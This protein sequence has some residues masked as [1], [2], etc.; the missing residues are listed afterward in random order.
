MKAMEQIFS[1]S[2]DTYKEAFPIVAG[3]MVQEVAENALEAANHT[4]RSAY[5]A[6][7]G[8][9]A[10]EKSIKNAQLLAFTLSRVVDHTLWMNRYANSLAAI[11]NSLGEFKVQTPKASSS[12]FLKDGRE[13]KVPVSHDG[14]VTV[15]LQRLTGQP[16]EIVMRINAVIQELD[17]CCRELD[18]ALKESD[19][20]YK[21]AMQMKESY[22]QLLE[23]AERTSVNIDQI[24]ASTETVGNEQ[25]DPLISLDAA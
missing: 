24:L 10:A 13:K 2:Q 17:D 20:G 25:R 5:V 23:T 6:K 11:L 12:E 14:D 21:L 16:S 7:E 19:L 15:Q 4:V 18:T 8:Q 1:I 3:V 22:C 9:D